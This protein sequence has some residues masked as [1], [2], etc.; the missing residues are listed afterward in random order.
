TSPDSDWQWVRLPRKIALAGGLVRFGIRRG[1]DGMSFDRFV[2]TDDS[3]YDPADV[4]SGLGP[5]D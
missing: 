1:E 2:I 3:D 5:I 4:E